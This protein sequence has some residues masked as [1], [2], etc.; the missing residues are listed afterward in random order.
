MIIRQN[1]IVA[2]GST[3]TSDVPE[4]SLGVARS[5]QKN[6]VGKAKDIIKN[7]RIKTTSNKTDK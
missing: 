7:L 3:I 1:A 4:N 2:A 6:L 5:N